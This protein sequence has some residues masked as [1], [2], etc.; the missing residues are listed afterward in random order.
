M[1]FWKKGNAFWGMIFSS[2]G[3]RQ[4]PQKVKALENLRPPKNRVNENLLSA[5]FK[6][7]VTLSPISQKADQ[8]L[9][10]FWIVTNITNGQ[11]PIKKFSIIF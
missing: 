1:F 3:V 11:R 5:W 8:Y 9:E 6:A 10:N 2:I 4:D 7:I